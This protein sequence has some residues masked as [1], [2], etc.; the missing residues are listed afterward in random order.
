MKTQQKNPDNVVFL[1]SRRPK[2]SVAGISGG[3]TSAFMAYRLPSSTVLCFQNTGKEHPKTID[4]LRRLEDDLRRPIVRLEYRSPPRGE[5]PRNS[6]FEVVSH[7]RL[8]MKGE[9]CRDLLESLA[10]FRKLHKNKPPIAPWARQRICT[11]YLKI[12][13]QRAYARSL[14]W[15]EWTA[16]V[17]LRFDEP[18]RVALM[19]ARNEARDDNDERA[20]LFDSK[21]TKRDVLSFWSRKSFDLEIPEYLGNCTGCFLKDESDL[22]MALLEPATDAEWWINIEKDFAPMRRGRPSFADVAREA[23]ARLAIRQALADGRLVI[24]RGDLSERR[25]KLIVRQ[26]RAPREEWSC[27]CASADAID[28]EDD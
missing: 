27:G 18:A 23:P 20:P 15:D 22:A 8:S 6:T 19:K 24:P 21:I 5:P 14:G 25:F 1:S 3:R 26:E 17:G 12:K 2:P 7:E 4:F 10:A 28:D 11:A 13:V 16:F 9:P